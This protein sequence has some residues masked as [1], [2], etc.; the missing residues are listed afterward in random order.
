[1]RVT[2]LLDLKLLFGYAESNPSSFGANR[3]N[4]Q[5]HRAFFTTTVRTV[6]HCT[7]LCVVVLLASNKFMYPFYL[8][9]DHDQCAVFT[10]S[11]KSLFK[12]TGR[13]FTTIMGQYGW[14]LSLRQFPSISHTSSMASTDYLR[15]VCIVASAFWGV[16]FSPA[17]ARISSYLC[18]LRIFYKG[19]QQFS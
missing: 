9:H 15:G 7:C 17:V 18:H 10:F 3:F 8:L 16:C 14:L 13:A 2:S 1:M 12:L 11:F 5:T 6:T 19:L 4:S